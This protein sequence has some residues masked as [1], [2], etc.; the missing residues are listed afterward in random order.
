MSDQNSAKSDGLE[1][2][3]ASG[4]DQTSTTK[5]LQ[6]M[7]Q[8]LKSTEARTKLNLILEPLSHAEREALIALAAISLQDDRN[9]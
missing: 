2:S 7:A 5:H 9:S 8:V 1:I 3:E 6:T 4:G